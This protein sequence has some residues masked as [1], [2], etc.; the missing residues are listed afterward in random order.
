MDGTPAAPPP[1]IPRFEQDLAEMFARLDVEHPVVI[2][3]GLG[4][5]LAI[6]VAT[7]RPDAVSGTVVI[8]TT[9]VFPGTENLSYAERRAAAT[10]A[11]AAVPRDPSLFLQMLKRDD[12]ATGV[13]DARL[14]DRIATFQSRSD[15]RAVAQWLTEEIESDLRPV[16]PR[17]AAPFLA[18]VSASANDESE[19]KAYAAAFFTSVPSVTVVTIAPARRFITFD[20]PDAL[21]TMI[22]SYLSAQP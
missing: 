8:D 22:D 3:S 18:I 20:A 19:R 1:L 5:V 6:D 2:G 15:S 21:R 9:P 16:L 4:G 14:V 11:A 17:I 10:A 12:R 7:R 13:L